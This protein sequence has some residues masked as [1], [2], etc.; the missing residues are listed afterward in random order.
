MA[1]PSDP[2]YPVMPQ[3]DDASGPARVQRSLPAKDVTNESIADAYVQF[4]LY[5]NPYYPSDVDTSELKRIFKCPPRSDGKDFNIYT[6]WELIQKFDSKEIKTWAQLAL[7]LGV[8]PPSAEKG[9]SVQKVQQYSVRLKRWMH[10]M[11]VDAFFEY[12]LGKRHTYFSDLPPPHDPHPAQGRDGVPAEEDLAIRA[13]DPSFRPKRGRKRNESPEEEAAQPKRPLLTTS[14]TFEGQTLYAQ[15]QS[16]HP[17][18]GIPLRARPDAYEQEPWEPTSAV[19][20]D[21]FPPRQGAP[22]SAVYPRANHDTKWSFHNADGPITP[23]PMSA[24]EPRRSLSNFEEPSSANAA[25]A[26]K[27]RS[28]RKHGPAVSS[29]WPSISAASGSK[30]RGRPPVNRNVQEGPFTTFPADPSS[31]RTPSS[32]RATPGAGPN[33]THGD[34]SPLQM[35]SAY[36]SPSMGHNGDGQQHAIGRPERLQ[37]QVPPHTG[38]PIRLATP[39]VLVNGESNGSARDR[40]PGYNE[41]HEYSGEQMRGD[42]YGHQPPGNDQ[43]QLRPA[44]TGAAYAE[45]KR[46]LATDLLRANFSGRRDRLRGPEAAR[47]A[48]AMLSR[49]EVPQMD[50]GTK[51][52]EAAR[53]AAA[54]WLGISSRLGFSG[55]SPCQE[56]EIVVHRFAV[57]PNGSRTP[58][59]PE[60]RA[61][62]VVERYEVSWNLGFGGVGGRFAVVGVELE[63]EASGPDDQAEDRAV[64][65]VSSV[66]GQPPE[67]ID[68]HAKFMALDMALRLMKGQLNR[69][70]DRVLEAV[71]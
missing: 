57:G 24:I 28:R 7:D 29:A 18:S 9:G 20:S 33:S 13:L 52:E 49:L 41:R 48:A 65:I 68:W 3:L 58:L 14:F 15:P 22:H 40:A 10:A 50:S 51:K 12:L 25:S 23:H 66:A 64:E 61:G 2:R 4:I 1:S 30:L 27:A 54:S 63:P 17:A 37:V 53:T 26:N 39:T 47:L 31:E 35:P 55:G 8:E 38:G 42:D 36:V 19:T 43:R 60:Q 62:H 59:E 46:I 67:E 6:L 44:E 34:R 16:A 71:L 32:Q 45:M 21:N 5:C 69:F 70:Q 56:K 11:H